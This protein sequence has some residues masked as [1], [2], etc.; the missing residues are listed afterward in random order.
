M[1]EEL[2]VNLL[3]TVDNIKKEHPELAQ[4]LEQFRID[5]QE[6]DQAMLAILSAQMIPS[7][8]YGTARESFGYA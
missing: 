5:Q 6:Y 3:E 7:N 4:L 1:T 2:Q 8:T